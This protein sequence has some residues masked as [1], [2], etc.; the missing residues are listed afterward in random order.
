MALGTA[1]TL[2]DFSFPR[3]G[4][5]EGVLLADTM[6]SPIF[7]NP[8][9]P[10]L[11]NPHAFVFG[12]SGSGKSF[13]NGKMIKDR[14]FGGDTVI[15]I[16]VGGTYRHLF[17]AIG[18][19]YIAYDPQNPP[20]RI[21]PF[22][23][24]GSETPD[25]EKIAFLVQFLGLIWKE[26]LQNNPL[27]PLEQAALSKLLLSY[28]RE[29]IQG[30][31]PSLKGFTQWLGQQTTVPGRLPVEDFLLVCEPFATGQYADLFNTDTVDEAYDKERLLC[32]ELGL[33]RQN[34]RLYPIVV[35]VVF[36]LIFRITAKNPDQTKFIDIEE[37]WSMLNSASQDYIEAFFRKG[38]KNNISIRLITQSVEE[39]AGTAVAGALKDNVST[40][41]LLYSEKDSTREQ[42]ANF[43]GLGDFDR[44]KY[45]SLSRKDSLFG[46]YRD[47]FIKEMDS[48]AIWRMS[49]SIFEHAILTSR[50]SERNVIAKYSQELGS[51]QQGVCRWVHQVTLAEDPSYKALTLKLNEEQLCQISA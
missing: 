36:D 45:A 32:F 42:V 10:T 28:Y 22:L 18:G 2:S 26:D 20:M 11:D 35:Q 13:F 43:L 19:K 7:Y 5:S 21:N 16:D 48:A 17:E 50:P 40:L 38:R 3:K 41:I 15:V 9:K 23:L 39:I 1:A 47:V 46:G 37:G 30:D 29:L 33:V 12:P 25:A 34:S 49:P 27:S 24:V 44:Q 31:V 14:F 8:K 51:I 6:G 4:D